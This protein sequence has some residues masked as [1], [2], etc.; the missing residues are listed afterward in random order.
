[1]NK[2]TS[3]GHAAAKQSCG[4][5]VEPANLVSRSRVVSSGADAAAGRGGAEVRPT[6]RRLEVLLL[7]SLCPWSG[8]CEDAACWMKCGDR[9]L[10]LSREA[11]PTEP[12]P[13]RGR[14]KQPHC[15]SL[16]VL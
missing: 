2:S 16:G 15:G 11:H 10:V 13:P 8:A 7:R 14:R 3:V 4:S 12:S 6:E 9:M 5:D 1:M